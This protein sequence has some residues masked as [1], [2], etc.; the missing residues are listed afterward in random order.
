MRLITLLVDRWRCQGVRQFVLRNRADADT[1]VEV[2][3]HDY[4]AMAEAFGVS[5][6]AD[7][8][9]IEE[10]LHSIGDADPAQV[11]ASIFRN[12]MSHNNDRR[13]RVDGR[14][15][16]TSASDRHQREASAR[17]QAVID[18]GGPDI[19]FQPICRA[20][21]GTIEGYEALSR[22][23]PTGGTT[24]TWFSDAAAIGLG[25][26][27]D[28]SA[29]RK[30]IQE[31][32]SLPDGTFVSLN[33]AAATLLGDTDVSDLL[34]EAGR[35]RRLV[36]EITEHAAIA[37]HDAVQPVLARLRRGG[38]AIAVD[39]VGAG[40]AG[41]RQLVL[42]EPDFI[43]LD[44]FVV[45]EMKGHPTKLAAAEFILALAKK[46]G[47]RCVFEGIETEEDF[48]TAKL[49]GADLLQGYHMGRPAPACRLSS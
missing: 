22:F 21:D 38:V 41:L 18:D 33:L 26:A 8:R 37:D 5:W 17:I 15:Q 31:S 11:S 40:Y 44:A 3:A 35:D 28:R 32:A 2:R 1:K 29:A 46:T 30:A 10:L 4:L 43:K 47:A 12:I 6:P 42:L 7:E 13:D 19:V 49:L 25:S 36:L 16:P 45:H 27:L 34:I 24:E 39:D 9:K 20:D 14:W 48:E 23:P